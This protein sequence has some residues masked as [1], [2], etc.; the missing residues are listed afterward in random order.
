MKALPQALKLGDGNTC[1]RPARIDQVA[2]RRIVP[3]QQRADPNPTALRIAPSDDYEFL[4]VET[5]RFQPRAPI[6]LIPTI[7]A[8]RDN[9]F[10]A[11][12]AGQTMESRALADLMIV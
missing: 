1:A 12:L 5:F 4:A 9:A 6:G 11:A 7:N 3:E 8:L 10:E 2:H